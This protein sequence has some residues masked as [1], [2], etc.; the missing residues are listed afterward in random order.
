MA[1]SA[2]TPFKRQRFSAGAITTSTPARPQDLGDGSGL[3]ATIRRWGST[4]GVFDDGSRTEPLWQ[5]Q[6]T[7]GGRQSF[8]YQLHGVCRE[9]LQA[10]PNENI[11]EL[12][13]LETEMHVKIL[14]GAPPAA[15]AQDPDGV[16]LEAWQPVVY[17]PTPAA[18][19]GIIHFIMQ[20]KVRTGQVLQ[21]PHFIAVFVMEPDARTPAMPTPWIKHTDHPLQQAAF[22]ALPPRGRRHVLLQVELDKMQQGQGQI[23]ANQ[24]AVREEDEQTPNSQLPTGT[25]AI[26]FFG[27]IY[28]FRELFDAANIQGGTVAQPD[29]S[30]DEYVR[31]LKATCSE[32]DKQRLTSILEQVLLQVP[33]YLVD[34]T[35]SQDDPLVSWLLTQPSV[36]LG[37]RSAESA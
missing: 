15:G 6:V 25:Y 37:E 1:K 19:L 22:R 36:H 33:V 12:T 30:K 35:G 28:G 34:Q 10:Y 8:G 18:G 26:M 11:R 21:L 29:G 20:H 23:P 27:G 14:H 17:A 7:H 16:G 5:I 3:V 31:H 13:Q 24:E 32:G 4:F 2:S 9:A